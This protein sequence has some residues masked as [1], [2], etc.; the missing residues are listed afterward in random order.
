MKEV[1]IDAK[2][3]TPGRVATEAVS[4]LLGKRSPSWAPNR[5]PDVSV[6]VKN[7][8][9]LRLSARKLRTKRYRRHS[10]WPG[11]FREEPLA[12]V[13]ERHPERVIRHAIEGMLPKNRLRSKALRRLKILLGEA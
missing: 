11:G 6:T 8:A 5:L 13:W 4:Y 9:G 7:V 12:R 10:G 2:G 3:R 1:I